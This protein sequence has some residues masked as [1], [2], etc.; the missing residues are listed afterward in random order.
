MFCL[1]GSVN[2]YKGPILSNKRKLFIH[3]G[4]LYQPLQGYTTGS[5]SHKMSYIAN[6]GMRIQGC[7][8]KISSIFQGSVFITQVLCR[9]IHTDSEGEFSISNGCHGDKPFHGLI[10]QH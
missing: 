6:E 2:I 1:V 10:S 7:C 9:L 5:S 4:L 8:E 3:G